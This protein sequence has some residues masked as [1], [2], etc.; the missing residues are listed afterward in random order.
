MKLVSESIQQFLNEAGINRYLNHMQKGDFAIMTASRNEYTPK[1][2]K[3][4]NKKL[5]EILQKQKAGYLDLIGHWEEIKQGKEQ[6]KVDVTEHSLLIPKPKS[7]SFENFL[8]FIIRLGLFT[9]QDAVL[10]GKEGLANL[11]FLD[12]PNKKVADIKRLGK[13]NF[14]KINQAYSQIRK[15][16]DATFVFEGI[17]LLAPKPEEELEISKI[18]EWLPK[19]KKYEKMYYLLA[20]N[21]EIKDLDFGL[22]QKKTPRTDLNMVMTFNYQ[23][24]ELEAYDLDEL[25][26]VVEI[27]RKIPE[28]AIAWYEWTQFEDKIPLTDGWIATTPPRS[29]H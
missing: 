7:M 12:I 16:P 8:K 29:E 23:G 20:S 22:P 3:A 11:Y 10:I 9:K 28:A 27:Y 1:Q 25:N 26:K 19:N 14:Q 6:E 4:R 15:K 17:D 13:V 24:D 18:K 21:P 5:G 2:N